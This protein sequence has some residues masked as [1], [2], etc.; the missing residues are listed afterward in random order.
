MRT[1]SLYSF[2]HNSPMPKKTHS[3]EGF[4]VRLEI[5]L[6]EANLLGK[7]VNGRHIPH[8]VAAKALRV[9]NHTIGKLL[10]GDR[11]PSEELKQRICD[12]TGVCMEWLMM[13][14]GPKRIEDSLDLTRLPKDAQQVMKS[15]YAQ[16]VGDVEPEEA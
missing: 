5:A 7:D 9:S 6:K 10:A 15:M 3:Y 12:V 13:N 8:E 2:R 11:N 4:E 14:R 1:Q 16:L